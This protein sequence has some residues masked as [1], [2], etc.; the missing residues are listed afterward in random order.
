M[1]NK[2]RVVTLFLWGTIVASAV[3]LTVFII[4]STVYRVETKKLSV[5][6]FYNF[7]IEVSFLHKKDNLEPFEIRVYDITT[8]EDFNV[9]AQKQD[10]TEISNVPVTGLK[11]PEQIIEVVLSETKDYCYFNADI[12]D[13]YSEDADH[14]AQI[15]VL[16]K[17]PQEYFVFGVY[18][19]AVNLYSGKNLPA[20]EKFE[21][22]TI[23][24]FY[25]IK[26]S[27]M[28][29]SKEIEKVVKIF[30]D[31][32]YIKQLEYLEQIKQQIQQTENLEQLNSIM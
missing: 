10:G 11:L 1:T 27:L 32:S 14:I 29:D 26:C 15:N 6:N 4:W 5:I 3:A 24:G 13:I 8:K 12:S 25:P 17:E 9:R 21:S 30:T 31:Y 28:Q 2:D 22:E 16:T 7:P 20:F 18:P 19:S 23:K